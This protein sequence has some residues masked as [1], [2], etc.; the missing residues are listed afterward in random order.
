MEADEYFLAYDALHNK[1]KG[2]VK[3]QLPL[4]SP[5]SCGIMKII[6]SQFDFMTG[7]ELKFLWEI[8]PSSTLV[9]VDL[10]GEDGS[11]ADAESLIDSGGSNQSV[12]FEEIDN[13]YQN[14]LKTVMDMEASMML[15]SFSTMDPYG[16]YA[17]MTQRYLNDYMS[18]SRT[19]T[20]TKT[21]TMDEFRD[22]P[23][24]SLKEEGFHDTCGLE[25]PPFSKNK[26]SPGS[27]PSPIQSPNE[28]GNLGR[29]M[30][31]KF[32]GTASERELEAVFNETDQP[33][34]SSTNDSLFKETD[35]NFSPD[36]TTNEDDALRRS[37]VDSGVGVSTHSDLS[38]A[39]QSPPITGN[40]EPGFL[41]STPEMAGTSRPL[42]SES[43]I[44]SSASP[45]PS[46]SGS[47]T[48]DPMDLFAEPFDLSDNYLSDEQWVVKTVL[49]EQICNSNHAQNPLQHKLIL[50]RAR[51]LLVSAYI[52]CSQSREKNT[53]IYAISFLM[54]SQRQDWYMDRQ[55]WFEKLISGFI[56]TLKASL[57]AEDSD[58]I[59]VL[60]TSELTRLMSLLSTMDQFALVS[61]QRPLMIK[62]TLF[63]D[64][65]PRRID[66]TFLAK[67]ISGCFQAQ[68]NCVL[69]GGNHELVA[70]LLHTLALFVPDED[71]WCCLRPYRHKYSPHIRLQAIRRAE[72]PSVVVSGAAS[73]WPVCLIDVD[74]G[75]VLI[76]ATY[77]RHRIIKA[78]YDSKSVRMVL[79][80]S[81][82]MKS[83]VKKTKTPSL[84]LSSCKI[85]ECVVTFLKNM[86]KL[87]MEESARKG[88][89][90]QLQLYITNLAEALI[91]YVRDASKPGDDE[92]E[93]GAKSRRFSIQEMR[94]AMD[95]TSDALF[96]AVLARSQLIEPDIAEFIYM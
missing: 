92:K 11:I 13:P 3:K 20:S 48:S 10:N 54:S 65:Q 17:N 87:P 42:R 47:K 79:E 64:K 95:M 93:C 85:M 57:F 83:M 8:T 61:P 6:W 24:K 16:N 9:R 35:V 73:S 72:A 66:K 76:S 45:C 52:F 59:L 94:K 33:K 82:V 49:A 81:E 88:F 36:G 19:T 25:P 1:E 38:A 58:D 32:P 18:D 26:H 86:D 15:D 21:L 77:G 23:L 91:A 5:E 53:V 68:G 96:Y 55:R 80:Q 84:E 46:A 7:P 40:F 30:A 37:C 2:F 50:S 63:C 43:P 4:K 31:E 34:R 60:I 41:T 14:D 89:C 27:L 62:N 67:A 75:T 70:R 51:H 78:R 69:F 22:T 74:R 71:Q 44:C 90:M 12:S 39:C 29:L 28:T 56:P